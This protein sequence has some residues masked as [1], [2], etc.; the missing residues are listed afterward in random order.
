[1]IGGPVLYLRVSCLVENLQDACDSRRQ[2]ALAEPQGLLGGKCIIVVGSYVL[3]CECDEWSELE[4]EHD[5]ADTG[6]GLGQRGG[7]SGK[8]GATSGYGTRWASDQRNEEYWRSV[9][10]SDD[11]HDAGAT[12]YVGESLVFKLYT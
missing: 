9:S 4:G 11:L 8:N 1:M 5:G 10:R 3:C 6:D 2:V 7:R 12:V